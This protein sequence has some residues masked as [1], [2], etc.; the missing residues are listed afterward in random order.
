MTSTEELGQKISTSALLKFGVRKFLAVDIFLYVKCLTTWMVS[1]IYMSYVVTMKTV[2]TLSKISGNG[3][4]CHMSGPAPVQK[5]D[6]EIQ[7]KVE[8]NH[9]CQ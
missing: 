6:M 9:M 8:E 2:Q 4:F 3:E 1:K 5:E 7:L